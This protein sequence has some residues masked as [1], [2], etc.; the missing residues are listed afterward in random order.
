MYNA[1]IEIGYECVRPDGAFF[2]FPRSPIADDAAFIKI[3]QS[4]LVLAVPGSGFGGPGHFR[5][6]YGVEDRVLEG[7]IPKFRQAFEMCTA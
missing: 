6:S 1:L 2:L 5:V 3:L 4:Q 7:A